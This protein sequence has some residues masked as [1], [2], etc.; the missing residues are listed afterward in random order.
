MKYCKHKSVR[1]SATKAAS[2]RLLNDIAVID[3]DLAAKLRPG[4][5]KFMESV[6]LTT[7]DSRNDTL[8]QL[9]DFFKLQSTTDK[10]EWLK[11]HKDVADT[12]KT[13]MDSMQS[14]NE[15]DD[16]PALDVST[17][18]PPALDDPE[19]SGAA[20]EPRFGLDTST[21]PNVLDKMQLDTKLRAY[22]ETQLTEFLANNVNAATVASAVPGYEAKFAALSFNDSLATAFDRVLNVLVSTLLDNY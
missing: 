11:Q 2:L 7:P 20:D 22:I 8:S 9:T 10:A 15:E 19:A 4:I 12:V 3:V 17:T 5:I 1:E 13:L 6:D 21:Q 14:V 16:E 18:P